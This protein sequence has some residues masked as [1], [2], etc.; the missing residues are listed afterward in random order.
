MI[1][2]NL[3]AN[4]TENIDIS[5]I[6]FKTSGLADESTD[7]SSAILIFDANNN[8]R[9]DIVYDSQ[10]GDTVFSFTDDGSITFSSL[11]EVITA[12]TS[13]Q[14]ILMY[15]LNGSGSPDETF[16]VYFDDFNQVTATG[17]SSSQSISPLGLP[18]NGN[19]MTISQIGTMTLA[20]ADNNPGDV[21]FGGT[22]PNLTMLAFTMTT[23]DVEDINI[24]SIRV[25]P[26]T[27][28]LHKGDFVDPEVRIYQDIDE[29]G[30]LDIN[31]D[32]FIT[33]ANYAGNGNSTPEPVTISISGETIPASSTVQWL[34]VNSITSSTAGNYA[35][36]SVLSSDLEG[37]GAVSL[38]SANVTGSNLVG[39]KK[40]HVT[41]TPGTLTFDT[42]TNN[43]EYRYISAGAQN[44]VMMQFQLAAD[45]VEDITITQIGVA[46]TGTGDD[47]SDIVSVR[48]Y[49]DGDNNGLLNTLYDTQL[50]TTTAPAS[51]NDTIS[52]SGFTETI[53]TG[54][55]KN[56]IA[57]Y[58]FN[59]DEN[60]L[61]ET[62][63]A[64]TG[65]ALITATGVTSG[66]SIY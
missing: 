53:S 25:I 1:Q 35:E 34:I 22:A 19:A 21:S 20:L 61:N 36:V 44:E 14:W 2:I 32:R 24:T 31:V 12:G 8:G 63:Q 54:T 7:I 18:V 27:N 58:N 62:Y 66:L 57:V 51:D 6:S 48:L 65:N 4:A 26:E 16:K 60:D 23:N 15:N 39:G 5:A 30:L 43:P 28:N 29:N 37:T 56:Y 33:S 49:L 17:A 45:P 11:S 64:Y 52:F 9:Y 46:M 13:E 42:G 47:P 10:I 50:G 38:E 3:S 40:T 55:A 41:G 59:G